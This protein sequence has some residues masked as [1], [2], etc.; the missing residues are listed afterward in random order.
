M[1]LGEEERRTSCVG[2]GDMAPPSSTT[3]STIA[4]QAGQS[5]VI[6]TIL[7]SGVLVHLQL[8]EAHPDLCEIGS[9][10]EETQ[11]LIQEHQQLLLKLKKHERGVFALLEQADRT[12]EEKSLDEGMTEERRREEGEVYE[13]MAASLSEAWSALISLLEKRQLLL[14]LAS[15]FYDAA[16]EFA[17]RIDD[18]EEFQ[19]RGVEVENTDRLQELLLTHT[20]LKRGLLEKSMLVLTQSTELLE[21]LRELQRAEA[22]QRHG[23]ELQAS[24]GLDEEDEEEEE[25]GCL[26]LSSSEEMVERLVEIL[27]DRRRQ[28]DQ[29]MKL[30]QKHLE[31]ILL[32]HQWEKQE[33]QVKHWFTTCAEIYLEKDQLGFS[34]T[35]N[36]DLLNQHKEFTAKAKDWSDSV[37]K[38]LAQASDLQSERVQEAALPEFQ[39]VE[40]KSRALR[41]QQEALWSRTKQRHTQLQEGHTFYTSANK[42]FAVLGDVE[43]QTKALKEQSLGLLELARK[44]QD[45]QRSIKETAA[46]PLQIGS[47]LLHSTSTHSAQ[48]AGVQRMLGYIQERVEGLSRECHAHR[49]L[50]NRKQQMVSTCEDLLEKVCVW[51]KATSSVLSSNTDPGDQLSLAE[52][53]LNKHLELQDQAQDT[54]HHAEAMTQVLEEIRGLEGEY[55]QSPVK[56]D[57]TR[58]ASMEQSSRAGLV[59]EELSNRASLVSEELKSLTRNLSTRVNT[60]RPYVALLH[61]AEEVGEQMASLRDFYSREPEEEASPT[62]STTPTSPTTPTSS[63]NGSRAVCKEQADVRWQAMLQRFLTVQDLARNYINSANMVSDQQTL[64][65][66]S[67]VCVVER[68]VEHLTRT[69]QELSELW[70]SWQLQLNSLQSG[71]K[72]QWKKYK[73]QLSKTFLHLRAVEEVLVPSSK[74][75]LGSDAHTVTRL[76]ENFNQA[77]PQFT[78]L[79]AEVEFMVR[80]SELLGLKGAP[81]QEKADKVAELLQIHQRVKD[82]VQEYQTLLHTAQQY[83]NLTDQLDQLLQ[84]GPA[85]SFSESSQTRTQLS[86]HQDRQNHASHLYNNALALGTDVC[87]TVQQS[88]ATGFCVLR[89][90]DRLARLQR[91]W[92]GW[93]SEAQLYEEELNNRLLYC[94]FKEDVTELRESLKDLKKRF[95]NMKFNYMK[96]KDRSRNLKAIRNQIQ[97]IDNYAEKLQVLKQRMQ[98][99]TARLSSPAERPLQGGSPREMEDAVNELQRIMGDFERSV[100]EHRQN[101]ELTVKLQQA[102]EEYQFWCDEA[103]AT[104]V[105]VGS[106]SSQCQTQQAVAVLYQQFEKFVWPTVPQQE[107]RVQ[108]ITE[109]ALRLHGPEEGKR[110]MEKTVSKHSEIVESI[111]ELSKGLKDLETQLQSEPKETGHTPELTTGAD[112]KEIPIKKLAAAAANRKAPLRKT[113]SMEQTERSE[114]RYRQETYSERT[115]VETSSSG[116]TTERTEEQHIS[117]YSCTH[118]FSL[119]CSPLEAERRAHA[120]HHQP[121]SGSET[122]ATPPPLVIGHSFSD[123]QREFQKKERSRVGGHR[124][125][126]GSRSCA[127]P[128]NSASETQEAELQQQEVMTEESLSNDEYECTSPDDMSL[129]PLSETPESNMVQSDL[130]DGY[131]LSSHSIHVNQY[132][133]QLNQC[134]PQSDPSGGSGP[135]PTAGLPGGTRFRSGSTSFLQSPLTIPAPSLMSTNISTILKNKAVSNMTSTLTSMVTSSSTTSSLL[136]GVPSPNLPQNSSLPP[137]CLG[138]SLNQGLHSSTVPKSSNLPL[139]SSVP[140]SLQ[141]SSSSGFPQGST[142]RPAIPGFSLD[143]GLAFPTQPQDGALSVGYP[144]LS[145]PLVP[146]SQLHQT[147]ISLHESLSGQT[148]VHDPAVTSSP[149]PASALA[150]QANSHVPQLLTSEQDPA[151]CRPTAIKEGISLTTQIQ[152]PPHVPPCAPGPPGFRKPLASATVMGG[153]PVTLEV[154]VTGEPEPTLTWSRDGEVLFSGPRLVLTQKDSK[155][156]L[157]IESASLSDVGL[158][159]VE[160]RNTHGAVS[161]GAALVV[162]SG[163]SWLLQDICSIISVDWHTWF[164]TLCVLL[165][166]LYLLLL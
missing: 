96:R 82:K 159:E 87:R 35:E 85:R 80:T 14:D 143:Q 123:I 50:A 161:S 125:Q 37:D 66:R 28:V 95:N 157:F 57:Q 49:V 112:G 142:L 102:T 116:S 42:A 122:Q 131:C 149:P 151:V 27:Q 69:K 101:L 62:R 7:K 19:T 24:V 146:S 118:T 105:R 79:N 41:E 21:S 40:E 110:Y 72:K 86:Q 38:L 55:E 126:E 78:Q 39:K 54:A 70:T 75:D 163:N 76:L 135:S 108:Q 34:L 46:Q 129:P 83:H 115:R 89:V 33:N 52:D 130:D 139:G 104:I 23:V 20:S 98:L 91:D 117:S 68:T 36:Q 43:R 29:D 166:L 156:S 99:L 22:L 73:E 45:L 152:G 26:A 30:Q 137:A 141:S 6:V 31:N 134:P 65:V 165:W 74:I 59:S 61:L 147:V 71:V 51:V 44:H 162:L 155:H 53:L 47:S 145:G 154:K 81:V 17:I 48:V 138:S 113:R 88:A 18:A 9:K 4:V 164:G 111:K 84:A 63:T 92:T 114:S 133:H 10:Q 58:R 140:Q 160:A 5:H 124:G 109:L 100:E 11:S 128:F 64:E 121:G 150:P 106:Y 2:K 67:S 97:Q 120:L 56:P 144:G 132:S 60:L 3:I 136:Q 107:N 148:C 77:K 25:E 32:L 13:A 158:Y 93:C 153:S 90:Q 127:G 15:R 12:A 16:L 94:L 8:T 119:S 1:T 103:S